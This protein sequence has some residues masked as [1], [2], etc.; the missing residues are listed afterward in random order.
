[1]ASSTTELSLYD[2]SL[3]NV[4]PEMKQDGVSSE[5]DVLFPELDDLTI[6]KDSK[7]SEPALSM[8][9]PPTRKVI[10][11][12]I[13]NNKEQD[14]ISY[15]SKNGLKIANPSFS[16][17]KNLLLKVAGGGLQSPALSFASNDSDTETEGGDMLKSDNS[18]TIVPCQ[19]QSMSKT[20]VT[21]REN[22]QRKK[23]YVSGLET[24]V[25]DLTCENKTLKS[26]VSKM[27][28]SIEELTTEVKYLKSVIANQSTL[29]ALLKNI[30][31][32]PGIQLSSSHSD[33]VQ[34]QCNSRGSK[35]KTKKAPCKRMATTLQDNMH[36]KENA[37]EEANPSSEEE[38][39]PAKRDKLDH[40]YASSSPMHRKGLQKSHIETAGVCLH[41]SNKK[42][43]LEFCASCSEK[44]ASGYM[45]RRESASGSMREK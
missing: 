11:F 35:G 21:A 39:H 23:T 17:N 30:D 10:A 14:L 28:G 32:T 12:K 36:G 6:F 9:A 38:P 34:T 24:S 18:R 4:I 37:P 5:E 41:V 15:L 2:D 20:A 1:M 33:E 8:P 43:S 22:R 16:N 3:S 45:L 26:Q 27:E 40:D 25:Q 44:A 42:V 13:S 29:S 7:E 31:A 19:V